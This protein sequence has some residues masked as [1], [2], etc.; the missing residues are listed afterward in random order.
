MG[1]E[2]YSILIRIDACSPKRGCAFPSREVGMGLAKVQ[3][4]LLSCGQF[5]EAEVSL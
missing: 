1:G 4:E 5:L 3:R 2:L